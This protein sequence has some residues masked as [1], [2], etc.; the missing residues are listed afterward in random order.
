MEIR[1]K[2]SEAKKEEQVQLKDLDIEVVESTELPVNMMRPIRH[3]RS[4]HME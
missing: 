3:I 4:N 1:N 2:A